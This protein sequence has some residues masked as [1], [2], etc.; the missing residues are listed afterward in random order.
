MICTFC[1]PKK[2]YIYDKM[3]HFLQIISK[4]HRKYRDKTSFEFIWSKSNEYYND[5]I[6]KDLTSDINQLLTSHKLGHL[7]DFTYPQVTFFLTLF[8]E[9]E[10]IV[11]TKSLFNKLSSNKKTINKEDLNEMTYFYS[12]EVYYRKIKTILWTMQINKKID[13]EKERK[14][15]LSK[16]IFEDEEKKK[17]E[18]EEKKKK[19]DEE[20]KKKEEKENNA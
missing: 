7:E 3:D 10:T 6:Q 20:K 15:K 4:L 11:H 19:E 12:T 8:N 18:D 5:V 2:K 14:E 17:K 16:Q 13:S 9:A 1:K